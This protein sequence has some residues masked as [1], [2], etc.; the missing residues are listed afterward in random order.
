ML[1]LQ[2]TLLL[3]LGCE[4][5]QGKG[6]YTNVMRSLKN[7]IEIEHFWEHNGLYLC[8]D[9]MCNNFD[10]FIFNIIKLN[11]NLNSTRTVSLLLLD[12]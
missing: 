6:F 3:I 5:I 8:R 12:G 11:F 1:R 7:L 9:I 4:A 2:V 10:K